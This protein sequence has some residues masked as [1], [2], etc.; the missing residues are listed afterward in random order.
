MSLQTDFDDWFAVH[1]TA[2]AVPQQMTQRHDHITQAVMVVDG[3]DNFANMTSG[4][5]L[6]AKMGLK[7]INLKQWHIILKAR[8]L[9]RL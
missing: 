9:S 8:H 7:S 2:A 3:C 5:I 6:I 1:S 4:D